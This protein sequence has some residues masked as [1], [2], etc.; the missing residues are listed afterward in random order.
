[1]KLT[2]ETLRQIIKEEIQLVMEGFP[3]NH[4]DYGDADDSDDRNINAIINNVAR[5]ILGH[6]ISSLE[7]A[8]DSIRRTKLLANAPEDQHD[9]IIQQAFK[10][11]LV[12]VLP[13][14]ESRDA[15]YKLAVNAP[16]PHSPSE[17]DID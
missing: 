6:N 1:M 3:Y 16:Y 15:R 5:Y 7:R 11:S 4:K 8:M 10:D 17:L 2:K 9:Y 13:E 14:P 12:D